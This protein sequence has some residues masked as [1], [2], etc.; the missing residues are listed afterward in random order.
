MNKNIAI[1]SIAFYRLTVGNLSEQE[2]MILSA[3]G[4]EFEKVWL[5]V[6]HHNYLVE[7]TI[8]N[9]H[10]YLRTLQKYKSRE[11]ESIFAFDAD[12]SDFVVGK[13]VVVRQTSY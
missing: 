2:E 12:C 1:R 4:V 9:G 5:H 10:R 13:V 7:T 6:A 3:S 11:F 8:I